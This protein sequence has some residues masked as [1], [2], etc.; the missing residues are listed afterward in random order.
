MR[1][2]FIVTIAILTNFTLSFAFADVNEDKLE[3]NIGDRMKNAPS[4]DQKKPPN[5]K[6]TVITKEIQDTLRNEKL[7]TFGKSVRVISANGHVTL[8]GRIVSKEEENLIIQKVRSVGGVTMV[9]NEMQII[10]EK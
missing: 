3:T 10:P 5:I 7:S 2:L 6:D 4:I 1:S 8:K 9:L